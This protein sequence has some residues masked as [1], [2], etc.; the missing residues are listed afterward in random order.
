MYQLS[1]PVC[2]STWRYTA[3][4]HA[5]YLHFMFCD[6]FNSYNFLHDCYRSSLTCSIYQNAASGGGGGGGGGS[7]AM[8]QP[9]MGKMGKRVR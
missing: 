1:G 6:D 9:L 5:S 7:L 4:L 3:F 8:P 2:K